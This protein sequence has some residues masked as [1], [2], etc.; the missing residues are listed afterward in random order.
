VH[1]PD[2]LVIVIDDDEGVCRAVARMLSASGYRAHTYVR[3]RDYLDEAEIVEPACVIADIRMPEIDG[4]AL[5]RAMRELGVEAPVIFMTATGDVGTV[6][7]AMKQGAVDLLPK[8]FGAD[9]LLAGVARAIDA[10][11]RSD[12]SHRSLLALWRAASK[13][14]P[15]EAEVCALVACGSPNKNVAMRIGTTEKTVKVHRGRVM[16][17]LAAPSLAELILMVD[18]L[19]AEPDRVTVRLDGMEIERPRAVEIMI[20]V[21]AIARSELAV[22]QESNTPLVP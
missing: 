9:N 2:P 11:R 7:S 21:M 5:V 8:P 18:L 6:V 12:D 17:K 13:L 20:R 4:I 19:R 22:S 15:R 14:T 16:Q 3:A 10:S 1:T